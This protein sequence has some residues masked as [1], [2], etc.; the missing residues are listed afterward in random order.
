MKFPQL[1]LVDGQVRYIEADEPPSLT[2]DQLKAKYDRLR[3]ILKR[4]KL[5]RTRGLENGQ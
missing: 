2:D 1:R 4:K 3:A 5:W